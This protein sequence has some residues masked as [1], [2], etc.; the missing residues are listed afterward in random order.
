ML[1]GKAEA[2]ESSA[3]EIARDSGLLGAIVESAPDAILVAD[4]D[5]R[6]V[7]A[8]GQAEELFGYDREE[9]LYRSVEMLIPEEQRK[10][11]VDHRATY[12][13]RPRRRSMGDYGRL[14]P[15]RKDG[16]HVCVEVS[17]SHMRR[18]QDDYVITV[19]RDV[20]KKIAE[21]E[22]LRYLS[23]HDGLTELYNRSF[24]E[25]EKA[26]LEQGRVAPI[27]V[28]V[29]DLDDL[30]KTNDRFGHA[31]GDRV[32]QRMAAVLRNAFRKEDVVARLGGDE[33]VVL[34]P[35]LDVKE[36]NEA[37]ERFREDLERHNDIMRVRPLRA[38][39]GAATARRPSALSAAL[40]AADERMYAAKRRQRRISEGVIE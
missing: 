35:G 20:S 36:R 25:A 26:R 12:L 3:E 29:V 16:S 9:L 30:K 31:E 17:L 34:L 11:H 27:S 32:L 8:N 18:G 24:F 37:V 33:F 22:R 6:I 10:R 2:L 40:R 1:V 38:S 13:K 7:L 21:E 4:A 19:L 14:E 28:L 23:T 39:I 5:G 15:R